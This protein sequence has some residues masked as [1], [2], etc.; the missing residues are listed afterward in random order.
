MEFR[1]EVP[2]RITP[3]PHVVHNQQVVTYS[4]RLN[5]NEIVTVF[6]QVRR[7]NVSRGLC[8]SYVDCVDL[9]N[10]VE[11][12]FIKYTLGMTTTTEKYVESR[13]LDLFGTSIFSVHG[14]FR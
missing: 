3:F 12:S 10:I 5:R 9:I 11:L 2:S 8:R 13:G 1:V 14:N 4:R 6:A 7:E